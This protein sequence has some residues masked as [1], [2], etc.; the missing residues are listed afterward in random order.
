MARIAVIRRVARLEQ[1]NFGD[2]RYCRDGVWE[3]RIDTGPGYRVY[4]AMV[5]P[6]QVLLLCAGD[7]RKQA[8]DIAR[9]AAYWNDWQQRKDNEK[10]SA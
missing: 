3:L 6:Q 8:D 4:Y 5:G 9:A 1:G 10:P 2:H 7:K